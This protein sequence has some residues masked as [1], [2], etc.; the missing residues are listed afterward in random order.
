MSTKEEVLQ[1]RTVDA[2]FKGLITQ[3]LND[4]YA[5]FEKTI[6]QTKKYPKFISIADVN[7][8]DVA[9]FMKDNNVPNDATFGG[10]DNGYDAWGDIGLC[11][12]IDVPTTD[13]DKTE[14]RRRAFSTAAFKFVRDVLISNGYKRVGFNSG[15][16][17]QF[18][19]TTVYDMYVNNDFDRLSIYYHLHFAKAS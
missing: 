3:A 10:V 14:F 5:K 16:L 15:L 18:K 8:L 7:P 1:N 17:D 4:A 13:K 19:D 9:Q 2:A 12:D 11:W 6:P